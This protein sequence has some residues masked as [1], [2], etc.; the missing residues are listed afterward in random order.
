MAKK[1]DDWY[2]RLNR[3]FRG[4]GIKRR[5]RDYRKPP[6]STAL[7]LFNKTQ[8]FVYSNAI[9]AY[10]QY[11]RLSRYCLSGETLIAINDEVG[12]ARIDELVDRF[13]AGEQFDVF[14]FDHS[15]G[16]IVAAQPSKVWKTGDMPVFEITFDDGSKLRATGNHPLM[17]R[18]G[19]YRRVDE[20]KTDDAIMPFRRHQFD[21]KLPKNRAT[22]RWIKSPTT[23][24]TCP[25]HVL[26]A[27]AAERKKTSR[28]MKERWSERGDLRINQ[29]QNLEK[30]RKA[31]NYLFGGTCEDHKVVSVVNTGEVVPVYDMTVPEYNN[32]SIILSHDAKNRVEDGI[33]VHNSDFSEMEYTPEIAAALDIYADESVS[34]DEAGKVLHIFSENRKLRGLLEEL[35]YDTLNID[36]N[37][38]MWV[39]NIVK[40]G[41]FFL[42]NDIAPGY[43]VM[44]VFPVPVNEVERE[45]GFDPDD[46]MAVRYRWITQGNVALENWQMTHFR[47]LGN[48]AFLPYGSSMIEPARRIWRQLILIEDAMMVYRVIRSPERRIFYVDVAGIPPE[49]VGNYMEAQERRLRSTSVIDKSTGRLDLRHSPLSVE[50]DYFIAVRGQE[51]G[52]RIDTL[53]G[54]QHVS[55][56]EDVEYIQKKLFAALKIPRAYLGY[57]EM[58]CLHGDTLIPLTDGRNVRIADLVKMHERGESIEVYSYD[59]ERQKIVPG[60]VTDAWQ[61]KTVDEL[62]EVELD[63]GT[64]VKCTGNHPFL[65][66]KG[67]YVRA[68]ELEPDTSL[69]PLYRRTSSRQAG[70]HLDGYEQVWDVQRKRWEYTHRVMAEDTC[71]VHESAGNERFDVIHHVDFDR[72]N[73]STEN[74]M[75]MGVDSHVRLHA[76][77]ANKTL[78]RPDVIEKRSQILREGWLTSDEHRDQSAEQMKYETTTPGRP[79]Y[80]WIHGDKISEKMSSVMKERW[81]DPDYRALKSRQ[82]KM[83][84]DDPDYRAKFMGDNHW[85]RKKNAGYD[86]KW[87]RQF[88]RKH[89]V[90]SV[91]QWRRKYRDSVADISPVGIR[92]VQSLIRREGY[93]N[94]KAFKRTIANNHKVVAVRKVTCDKVPVYDLTVE[95]KHNFALV[96]RD[97]TNSGIIVHNS[98]KATLA[99]EDIRFSRTIQQVQKV[100]IAELQ[101]IAY[102]HLFMNGYE[103]DD[104]FNFE[105]KLNN[106]SS[107]AQQQKLEL[108]ARKFEIVGN[109]LEVGNGQVFPTSYLLRTI[110]DMSESKQKQLSDEIVEDVQR[111]S[112][113]EKISD[114]ATPES[115]GFTGGGGFE[116]AGGLGDADADFGDDLGDEPF[117]TG[118][119]GAAGGGEEEPATGGDEGGGLEDLFQGDKPK[120][121]LLDADSDDST[122]EQ[123][124]SLLDADNDD[125]EEDDEDDD[126]TGADD[127]GG[128]RTSNKSSS[129]LK[130]KR[131][132]R[133]RNQQR[134]GAGET[135]MP[136][137]ARMTG[138]RDPQDSP[139]DS[140]ILSNPL[141]DSLSVKLEQL[142]SVNTRDPSV[143]R[144]RVDLMEKLDALQ[145]LENYMADAEPD[146]EPMTPIATAD[147]R[148]IFTRLDDVFGEELDKLRFN[149]DAGGLLSE[150]VGDD[151]WDPVDEVLNE[152]EDAHAEVNED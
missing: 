119:E 105:L 65:L 127:E 29:K 82:N 54:G 69:M 133:R 103:G 123:S 86:I 27:E 95:G 97:D 42:F 73:N 108:F 89:N 113:L 125:D 149:I 32:F 99:Q 102:I 148:S 151:D 20:L 129:E 30:R 56:T 80:E 50:E 25:E 53:S 96:G 36:F 49:E 138:M 7:E 55:A 114:G 93:D 135:H 15:T 67:E 106:P 110:F 74:L 126:G 51:S 132:N 43:G 91:N 117:D 17:L 45:E 33:V 109:A 118:D 100:V 57:D 134:H 81:Q 121:Q 104:M 6:T 88:C 4:P 11:D 44:Q 48:D 35:F 131:R 115:V 12:H 98:S 64:V 41:D 21:S 2:A 140:S 76:K 26:V 28:I 136:D 66:R 10:G 87:L 5:V 39:R 150:S 23:G 145:F 71:V 120:G 37:L 68:D 46:P 147:L 40:Y 130:R 139:L 128:I 19:S 9:N 62:Y 144:E 47:M 101:K 77:H 146:P 22:Y 116:P 90:T 152:F 75:R 137:F 112:A 122:S 18:D 83:L 58:L 78:Q 143:I 142:M 70:Q 24:E 1:N 31:K 38:R 94:W 141:K 72:S 124:P 85:L 111:R 107:I 60:K 34:Q 79:L 16:D 84:W 3:L 61:T 92:Y 52:T 63:D 8:S 14:A 59:I 13:N